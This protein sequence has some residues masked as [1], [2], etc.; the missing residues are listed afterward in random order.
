VPEPKPDKA[1][2][3]DIEADVDH[4]VAACG[5]DARAAIRALFV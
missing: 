4:A 2:P 5:G 3:R 1:K